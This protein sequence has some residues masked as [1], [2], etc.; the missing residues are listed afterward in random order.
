MK[1]YLLLKFLKYIFKEYIFIFLISAILLLSNIS[2]SFGDENVF[3]INDIKIEET[4]DVNFSRDKFLNKAFYDSFYN[5]INKILLTRDLKKVENIQLAQI[6]QLMN[7]FQILDE[8]YL[9]NVYKANIK[10]VYNEERVR[11]F[12][13][14]R[15]VSFT[16]PDNISSVFFPVFYINDEIQSFRENFFYN[17][18]N[19]IKIKNELINFILPLEDLDDFAEIMRMKNNIENLDIDYLINKYN[20]KNYVF[21]LME[22]QREKL[23]IYLR[24]NFNNNKTSKNIIYKIKNVKDEEILTFILKDLK[25][26][27]VDLWKEQN[28]INLLMPL[29]IQL[30]FQ[31]LKIDDLDNI[32]SVLNNI[33]IIENYTLKEFN[34]NNSL[35]KI[36]YYGNPKKL[37]SEL[38]KFGYD[39]KNNQGEWE[40]YNK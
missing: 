18:W 39:L 24:T 31:H 12:L 4:I 6:K 10:I 38:S 16:L 5:L 15:N 3:T 25:L 40:I 36:Y 1:N 22:F 9:S 37:K 21:A 2:K 13:A 7:G 27:I 26:Q 29:S 28:L 14:K 23:N 35:Y 30:K 34:I 19:E 11:K 32:R 8:S 17:N 20:E 33:S